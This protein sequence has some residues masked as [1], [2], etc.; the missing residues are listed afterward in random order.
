MHSNLPT[1][2]VTF[3]FTDV[4]NSTPLWDKHPEAMKSALAKHDSLVR[5]ISLLHNGR[6][7]KT[8]GDGFHV[9]FA[10]ATDAVQ[11]AIHAQQAIQKDSWDDVAI[12]VRMGIHTGEAELRDGDYFGGTL[13]LAARFQ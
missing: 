10:T 7:I 9:V 13:N 8:T 2:T 6:I 1:G 11:A 4:E 5:S 12:K 3:L